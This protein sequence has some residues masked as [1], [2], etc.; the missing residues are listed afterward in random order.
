MNVPLRSR[1]MLW[2][3][4]TGSPDPSIIEHVWDYYGHR[5]Q[6]SA[7]LQAIEGLFRQVRALFVSAEYT[8]HRIDARVR[9]RVS[10]TQ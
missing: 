10:D 7:N 6:P 3:S 1:V 5:L 4:F 8:E 9:V 2:S